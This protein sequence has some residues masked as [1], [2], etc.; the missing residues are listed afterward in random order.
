M[1]IVLRTGL[2]VLIAACLISFIGC[3]KKADENKPMTQ[4]QAEAD[5]MNVEQLKAAAMEYKNA[6]AAKKAELK[7]V[8]DKLKAI[9]ATEQLGDKAKKLQEEVVNIGK[10][11]NALTERFDVYY[12]KLKEKGG[13]VSGLEI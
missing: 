2:C 12:N 6:I 1:N 11:V 9:P 13:D 3:G 7:K 8:A 10:S 5:K 4:V